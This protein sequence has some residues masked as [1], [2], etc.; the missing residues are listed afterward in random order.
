MYNKFYGFSEKPFEVT[1]DPRFLYL[2]SSHR[3]AL[4]CMIDGIK[5]RRG[6]ISVTGEPGTGKTTLV[7]SL[8]SSLNRYEAKVKTVYIF[9]STITFRDLLKNTL[10]ELGLR[11]EGEGQKSLSNRL[12]E[13]LTQMDADETIAIIIDEAHNL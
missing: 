9:H 6:F 2:T 3:R 13:Y 11:A 8:L 5:N 12:A 4:D 10:L 1:P 7:Y